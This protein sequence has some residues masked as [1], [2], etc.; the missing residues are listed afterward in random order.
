MPHGELHQRKI[1]KN[2]AM[3]GLIFGLVALI[4]AISIFRMAAN[5]PDTP[6]D[7]QPN[8]AAPASASEQPVPATTPDATPQ[9]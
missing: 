9:P 1:G 5:T 2:L 3:L 6:P 4:F 7:T 8:T